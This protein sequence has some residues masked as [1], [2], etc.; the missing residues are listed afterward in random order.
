MMWRITFESNL[1]T[2]LSETYGD[3]ILNH[4]DAFQ[5]HHILMF[6]VINKLSVGLLKAMTSPSVVLTY[7]SLQL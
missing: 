6:I 4:C 3:F 1:E 5:K 7:R 2:V